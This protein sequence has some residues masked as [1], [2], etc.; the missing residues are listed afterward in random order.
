MA[1]IVMPREADSA[2]LAAELA[3]VQGRAGCSRTSGMLKDERDVQRRVGLDLQYC[4]MY[5]TSE[6][7]NY[8]LEKIIDKQTAEVY[9]LCKEKDHF[10]GKYYEAINEFFYLPALC[11]NC[12]FSIW[13]RQTSS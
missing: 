6:L 12:S 4:N 13:A 8:Q 7:H 10:R 2:E 9:T 11:F 1:I 3:H 5:R